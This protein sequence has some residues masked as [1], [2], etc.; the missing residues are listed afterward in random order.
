MVMIYTSM[1]CEN[2]RFQGQIIYKFK[3]LGVVDQWEKAIIILGHI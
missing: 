1:E 2:Y 3:I